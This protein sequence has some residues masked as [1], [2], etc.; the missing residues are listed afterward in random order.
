M[1]FKHLRDRCEARLRELV[2]PS[3]F[4]VQALC[5]SVEVR[6]G[7]RIFL[8]PVVSKSE[9]GGAWVAGTAGD[10]IFYEQET[11]PLHQ[12]HIILHEVSHLICNHQAA[13]VTKG[14]LSRLL[15]PDLDAETVASVLRRA[16]YSAEDEQEAELLASLILQ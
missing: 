4:D 11:T 14:E 15:L 12:E 10:F 7:R 16:T 9:V 3:P 13:S 8:C 5:D 1:E 6:R 2:L